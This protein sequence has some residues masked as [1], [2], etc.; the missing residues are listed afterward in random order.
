MLVFTIEQINYMI[1]S[2]RYMASH[3]GSIMPPDS[4]LQ[5]KLSV[6]ECQANNLR[7]FAQRDITPE[8]YLTEPTG[9]TVSGRDGEADIITWKLPNKRAGTEDTYFA[10]EHGNIIGNIDEYKALQSMRNPSADIQEAREALINSKYPISDSDAAMIFLTQ[11][12]NLYLPTELKDFYSDILK[13]EIL[14]GIK[15]SLSRPMQKWYD[16]SLNGNNAVEGMRRYENR[17]F[18]NKA[19]SSGTSRRAQ[20]FRRD[21][22]TIIEHDPREEVTSFAASVL[23]TAGQRPHQR[24]QWLA[25]MR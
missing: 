12:S 5:T 14:V 2:I 15:S 7:A 18:I 10:M 11:A 3:Q 23:N 6:L 9:L 21:L 1:E 17:N 22:Q 20:I 19:L 8:D 16:N 24:Y 13:T 4:K 25:G